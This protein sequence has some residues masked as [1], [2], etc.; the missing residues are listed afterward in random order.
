MIFHSS[1]NSNAIIHTHIT[2]ID[3]TKNVKVCEIFKIN[4]VINTNVTCIGEMKNT[5]Q[6][7]PDESH[8]HQKKHTSNFYKAQVCFLKDYKK[9]LNP[10]ILF[11]TI[12]QKQSHS[13]LFIF[14]FTIAQSLTHRLFHLHTLVNSKVRLPPNQFSHLLSR[15]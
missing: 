11:T 13:T 9:Q 10:L 2:C 3:K 14:I 8:L 4:A 7:R 6:T 1:Y 15:P 12:G 5:I